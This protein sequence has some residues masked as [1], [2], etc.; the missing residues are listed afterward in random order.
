MLGDES[1][2]PRKPEHLTLRVMSFHEAVAVEE[3]CFASF[4]GDLLPL[5]KCPW[6]KAQGHPSGPKFLGVATTPEVG[7]VVARVGVAQASAL[8][9]EDGVEASYEHV[10]RYANQ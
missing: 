8:G 3:D 5:I 10:G 4:Q 6:H 2:K 1:T 9:V 7:Q